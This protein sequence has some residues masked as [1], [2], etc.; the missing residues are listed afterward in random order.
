MAGRMNVRYFI[1]VLTLFMIVPGY[2]ASDRDKSL[3]MV[4]QEV[5]ALRQEVN[6]LKAEVNQLKHEKAATQKVTVS[7]TVSEPEAAAVETSG[8][9]TPD[10]D[11]SFEEHAI[12]RLGGIPILASPYLGVR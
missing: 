1:G 12:T 5:S 9:Q 6:D 7:K 11:E 10:Q 4:L 2:A 3:Q 8:Q